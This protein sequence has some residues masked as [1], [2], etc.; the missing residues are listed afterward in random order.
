MNESRVNIIIDDL[1]LR[2]PKGRLKKLTKNDYQIQEK[3]D[4]DRDTH[5]KNV[6]C[7]NRSE[8]WGWRK[9]DLFDLGFK[10]SCDVEEYVKDRW[11]KN[12]IT[13]RGG[14]G[15]KRA[16]L[17]RRTRRIWERIQPGIKAVVNEGGQGVYSIKGGGYG[18]ESFGHIFAESKA[19]AESIASVM[20][21]HVLTKHDQE[22]EGSPIK[23]ALI[24]R[25]DIDLAMEQNSRYFKDMTGSIKN[26]ADRIINLQARINRKTEQ[27]AIMKD[28]QAELVSSALSKG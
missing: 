13:H 15:S 27:L 20:F 14:Y 9:E 3:Y 7:T 1:L 6:I 21:F 25:G 2:Y 18:G 22:C 4:Y 12:E 23:A 8:Y 10:R 16:T 24:S 26:D 17:T 5:V 19:K 11:F 28:L